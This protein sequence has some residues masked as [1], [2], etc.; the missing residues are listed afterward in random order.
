MGKNCERCADMEAREL[1][2]RQELEAERARSR[3]R[4][5]L[6][7]GE[8]TESKLAKAERERDEARADGIASASHG[9]CEDLLDQ[10]DATLAALEAD[11]AAKTAALKRISRGET[12]PGYHG[13]HEHPLVAMAQEVIHGAQ[14]IAR[15][16]LASSPGAAFGRLARARAVVE[17]ARK[18]DRDS[19]SNFYLYGPPTTGRQQENRNPHGP[20]V[21]WQSLHDLHAA[22]A[23]HDAQAK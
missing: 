7:T 20:V 8:E 10:K 14:A 9:G 4:E 2:L 11:L 6:R 17:A 23:A 16:A 19:S 12:I 5:V 3:A 1:G 18:V 21:D 15:E 22:L 13:E